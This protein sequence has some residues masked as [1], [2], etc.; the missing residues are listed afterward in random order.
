MQV[1]PWLGHGPQSPGPRRSRDQMCKKM[2]RELGEVVG[3]MRPPSFVREG[4]QEDI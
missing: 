1:E 3:V 2:G 4:V